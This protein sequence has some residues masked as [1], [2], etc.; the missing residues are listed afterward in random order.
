[1]P[2]LPVVYA[3]LFEKSIKSWRYKDVFSTKFTSTHPPTIDLDDETI[4]FIVRHFQGYSMINTSATLEGVDVKGTVFE[5]MVGG[6][7]RGELGA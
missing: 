1:M 2:T 5:K 6:T 3:R 7:F 4:S